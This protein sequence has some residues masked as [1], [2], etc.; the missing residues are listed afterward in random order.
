MKL[1]RPSL[2]VISRLL[3][4]GCTLP[5][6][7]KLSAQS[8]ATAAPTAAAAPESPA[9]AAPGESPIVLN[10]FNVTT[11]KDTGYLATNSAS[12]TRI[13]MVIQNT[14]MNI[15][16]VT[17]ELIDDIGSTDLTT[18]LN[19]TAGVAAGYGNFATRTGGDAAFTLNGLNAAIFRD[20]FAAFGVVDTADVERFEVVS[21][22]ASV[23]YGNSAPGGL[24]NIVTKQPNSRQGGYIKTTV[25][26][27]GKERFELDYDQPLTSDNSLLAR[28]NFAQTDG[29]NHR[30]FQ[31]TSN[32]FYAPA[33]SWQVFKHLKIT[34]DVEILHEDGE[35][36]SYVPADAV[37]GTTI[38]FDVYK[39]IPLD[40]NL[41]GPNTIERRHKYTTTTLID[42]SIVDNL[43]GRLSFNGWK[44]TEAGQS[45]NQGFYNQPA[46]PGLL[47][48]YPYYVAINETQW[49]VRDDW[50]W[51][52]NLGPVHNKLIV[53]ADRS[54]DDTYQFQ[55]VNN[56]LAKYINPLL[57]D[58]YPVSFFNYPTYTGL[59]NGWTINPPYPSRGTTALNAVYVSDVISAFNDRINILVG[60]RYTSIK[61]SNKLNGL[62]DTTSQYSP[63]IS[64]LIKATDW[65]GVYASYSTSMT[66]NGLQADGHIFPPQ[67]GFGQEG[68]IKL[69][70]FNHMLVGSVAAFE[71]QQKGIVNSVFVINSAG[72]ST[73]F[74]QASGAQRATGWHTDWVLTL[75]PELQ[76]TLGY[77]NVTAVVNIGA[78]G[79]TPT[80]VSP[81]QGLPPPESPK[82]TATALG[83]YTFRHGPWK[84]F[85]LGAGFTYHD[86]FRSKAMAIG[87]PKY[88]VDYLPAAGV[89]SA[90]A[91][92]Q[93]KAFKHLM[94]V[95]L[96][97][98]NLTNLRYENIEATG[99]GTIAPPINVSGSLEIAF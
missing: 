73:Q 84:G 49:A 86:A 83:K 48:I 71:V 7:S 3:T 81:N 67:L 37:P 14:P 39:T 18:A 93:F 11:D 16:V 88:A 32:Q 61:V 52:M 8:A 96:R 17:R 91:G 95:S 85:S 30:R 47:Q 92:Y 55:A 24:I 43:T 44:N 9:A 76:F 64:G 40:Y 10:P 99:G 19:Y 25:D 63:Q 42:F 80:A 5:A 98:G 27:W 41:A 68:G 22:P 77:A 57:F 46:A 74:S 6:I 12:A 54:F 45:I 78:A 79:T 62:S 13:N 21:G 60:D 97:G 58:Q 69:D 50:L 2:A 53:G 59:G 38:L 90:F 4:L 1:N 23:F 36:P 31:K 70:V 35:V 34:E 65:L 87:A 89:V 94:D 75:N 72:L 28:F 82:N 66:P 20:G 33:I 26:Q 15:N 29:G 56:P 51:Q